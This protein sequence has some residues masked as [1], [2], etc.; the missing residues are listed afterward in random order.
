MSIGSEAIVSFAAVVIEPFTNVLVVVANDWLPFETVVVV[1]SET[2]VVNTVVVVVVELSSAATDCCS[3]RRVVATN[4]SAA[5]IVVVGLFSVQQFDEGVSFSPSDRTITHSL[6]LSLC[7]HCSDSNCLW[8]AV[9]ADTA[10]ETDVCSTSFGL[11]SRPTAAQQL[12][13]Q[14]QCQCRSQQCW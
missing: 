6:A 4:R 14:H 11:H 8:R 3:N 12:E 7:C 2:V 1:A 10:R 13:Q 9:D 5:I